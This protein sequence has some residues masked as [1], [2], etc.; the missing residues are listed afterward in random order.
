[1]CKLYERKLKLI[2]R[3]VS[4]ETEKEYEESKECNILEEHYR[5]KGVDIEGITCGKQKA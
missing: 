3:G 5:L 2:L 4:R 1:M